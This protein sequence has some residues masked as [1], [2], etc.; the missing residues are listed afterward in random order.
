[1][2]NYTALSTCSATG[3][4]VAY[5]LPVEDGRVRHAVVNPAEYLGPNSAYEQRR[6]FEWGY[7]GAIA[8]R[9][10]D[11]A[12]AEYCYNRV[13]DLKTMYGY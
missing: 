13:Q 12:T 10:G 6:A 9:N 8:E 5:T 4:N 3:S 7:L 11:I 2:T 1:M